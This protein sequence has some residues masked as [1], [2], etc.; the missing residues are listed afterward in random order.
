MQEA[1]GV[2]EFHNVT[3]Y[4]AASEVERTAV[5][6]REVLHLRS[7]FEQPD[8][9]ACF[10]LVGAGVA[11]CIHEAEDGHPAGTTEL[12]FWTEDGEGFAH[13]AASLGFGT[14]EVTI[15]KTDPAT[16]QVMWNETFAEQQLIDAGG[17][18][19]RL[20]SRRLGR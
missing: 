6:Y 3:V 1:S 15:H 10:A 4:V 8:H 19:V 12:F 9:I 20:H 13:Q 17:T 11:L 5:L 14:A 18:Q 16:G 2:P 7:V